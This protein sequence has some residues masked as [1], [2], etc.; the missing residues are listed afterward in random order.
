MKKEQKAKE[1]EELEAKKKAAEPKEIYPQ[2]YMSDTVRSTLESVIKE[3]KTEAQK[4]FHYNKDFDIEQ[5]D[6]EIEGIFIFI[7]FL[8]SFLFDIYQIYI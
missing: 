2:L 4:T 3:L 6:V 7:R 5:S 8:L 1:K